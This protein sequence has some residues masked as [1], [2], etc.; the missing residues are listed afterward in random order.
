[1]NFYQALASIYLLTVHQAILLKLTGIEL[2]ILKKPESSRSKFNAFIRFIL[3]ITGGLL[4]NAA[5]RQ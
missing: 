1:M 4:G 3:L 2:F 5:R